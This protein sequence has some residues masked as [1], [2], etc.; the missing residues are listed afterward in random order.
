MRAADRAECEALGRT[1][2]DALRNGLR[3]S[4]ETYTAITEERPVAM[5]GV[6]PDSLLGGTGTAWML[7]TDE[8][9]AQGRALLTYGPLVIGMWLERFE[10]LGNIVSVENDAAIRLLR[11]WGAEIGETPVTYRGVDFLP[12]VIRRAAIQGERLVA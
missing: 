6:V 8:I 3:C 12:F 7:G 11:R 1:P 4:L 10:E 5:L 2:K 9:F